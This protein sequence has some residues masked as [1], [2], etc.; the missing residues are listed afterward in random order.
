MKIEKNIPVPES[1]RARKYPFLEMDV[2]DSVYFEGEKING[3]AYR[4]AMTTGR[5]WNQKFVARKE[6]EGIRIWRAE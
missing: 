3:R 6:N 4:A 1:T 2:G 5:R